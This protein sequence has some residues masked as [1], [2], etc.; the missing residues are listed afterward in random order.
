MKMLYILLA[1]AWLFSSCKKTDNVVTRIV[2]PVYPVITLNGAPLLSSGVGGTYTDPGAVAY[3]S[4]TGQST[5]LTPYAN[6]VDLSQAGFYSVNFIAKNA[7]GY[8]TYASRLV[9]ATTVPASDDISGTYHRVPNGAVVNITKVGT[10]AYK[11]DNVG[12]VPNNPAFIF[13]F[14]IGFTDLNNFQGPTQSTPI[15]DLS[16]AGPVIIRNGATI[17]LK[18]QV[19]NPNF[20]ASVRTFVKN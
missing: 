15:G 8:R 7:Y 9:L 6:N 10:G 5:Q 2:T 1:T 17:T 3:D 4:L 14:Y 11:V 16:I 13:P 20:G 18:W 19:I 12:G